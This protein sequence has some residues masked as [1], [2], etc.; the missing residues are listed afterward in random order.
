[1]TPSDRSRS[2]LERFLGLFT[3]MHPGEGPSALLLSLNLFL[4]LV[5]YY[6]LKPVREA[7]ILAGGGAEVKSY[8]AAG[9]ALLLLGAVP[10]YGWLAARV[11]RRRLIN[12]VTLFF[13]ACLVAFYLLAQA[14]VPLGIVFFLWVGVFNLMVPTQLWA[15]ANDLYTPEAGKR[16][17][18]LVAFGASVGAVTGSWIAGQL[19]GPF[20]V[21][22][23]ML[24]AAG[25]LVVSL[26][27]TNVVDAR[28]RGGTSRRSARAG[29]EPLA[30]GSAFACVLRSRYLVLIG[31][32]ALVLNWVNTTG[33]YLLGRIALE[34]AEKLAGT[35]AAGGLDTE[36]LVGRFY[37]TFFTGVNLAGL[38]LQLFVVS[39]VLKYLGVGVAVLVL[40]LLAL[41]GYAVAAA[42]PVLAVVRWTKTAEN[43][44]D[45]SLQSTVRQVLFLPTTREEKYKAKQVTDTIFVRAGDVLSAML[46]F[47]G[48]TWLGFAVRDFALVN[49]LLACVWLGIAIAIG[50]EHARRTA[51]ARG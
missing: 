46:V 47:A 14:K 35:A 11:P 49:V 41:G 43:A 34:S 23:L 3:E 45:Y 1:V 5:A 22:Q 8:A 26:L 6:L 7:L 16:I 42:M 19:I 30:P 33:E 13:A 21:Y 17:F 39:R 12:V 20:G 37:A 18:V 24:V 27:L 51:T 28:Q 29:D 32:L 31:V 2:P 4:I 50:R 38:A 9:Q 15:F 10:L 44:T 36:Q 40:P 25:L 48:T